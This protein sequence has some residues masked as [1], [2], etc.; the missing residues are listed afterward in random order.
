ML[1]RSS[2]RL[3]P[4]QRPLERVAVAHVGGTVLV[5]RHDG[6]GVAPTER[7]R[8]PMVVVR[9]RPLLGRDASAQAPTPPMPGKARAAGRE[10][11]PEGCPRRRG[12]D[13]ARLAGG[14]EVV[15]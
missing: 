5:E 3:H 9:D 1:A 14:R 6:T 12:P 8:D 7:P 4:P 10:D 15:M 13:V 11:E 2:P